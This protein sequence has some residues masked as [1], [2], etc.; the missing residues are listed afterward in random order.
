MPP[1]PLT[2]PEKA[3]ETIPPPSGRHETPLMLCRVVMTRRIPVGIFHK[4][5]AQ[6]AAQTTAPGHRSVSGRRSIADQ[7]HAIVMTIE[8][9]AVALS[10]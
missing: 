9:T 5:V 4:F 8:V 6:H 7:R 1:P 10:L 2:D 3:C